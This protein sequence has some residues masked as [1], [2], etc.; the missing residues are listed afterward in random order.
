[1]EALLKDIGIT[2][3]LF[4]QVHLY[5]GVNFINSITEF[6]SILNYLRIRVKEQGNQPF[7]IEII[8][9]AEKQVVSYRDFYSTLLSVGYILKSVYNV[10]LQTRVAILPENTVASVY[11][12]LGIMLCGA[13]AVIINPNEPIDRINQQIIKTDCL[14]TIVDTTNNNPSINYKATAQDIINQGN[15][16]ASSSNNMDMEFYFNSYQPALIIFT[17]GTTST[18]KPVVQMHYNVAVNSYALVRHHQLDKNQRLLCTLP[19]YHV[20][21]LEFTIFSSM[22]AGSTVVLCD[23]FDP[24]LYLGLIEKYKIT[25]ASLVPPLLNSI[26]DES[27]SNFDLLNLRYFVTAAAPLSVKTSKLIWEKFRKRIIQG[28]G[29]TE[30]T[31][32]STLMP[33][34]ISDE[35]YQYLML[36]CDIPSIGHEVFGNEVAIFRSDGTLAENGEEGEICMRGHNVMAGYLYNPEAT[37]EC[38]R[39]GWFHSG[40][41]G[42]FVSLPSIKEKFIKITGRIKNVIKVSGHAV[43]LD[44]IDRLILAM[45]AV[46]DCVTCAIDDPSTGELPLS[47]VVR[48][49]NSL[50]EVDIIDTLVKSINYQSL[51][52]TIIFVPSIPRMKNGKVNRSYVLKELLKNI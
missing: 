4:E 44:E 13:T 17:T 52:R 26:I 5:K 33:T 19:I 35:V 7:I 8:N 2:A 27:N 32:F 45:E 36:D 29:L 1:M 18:S 37:E 16:I 50:S 25:I 11:I 15:S 20:N 48:K 41:I 9:G 49:N 28:Y 46:Q 30:T 31:N 23:G 3:E 38:F 21:G 24:F 10:D 22:I 39:N 40:D 42:K 14:F 43:S 47:F 51:P 6:N 12:I 34:N